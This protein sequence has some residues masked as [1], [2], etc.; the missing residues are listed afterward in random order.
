M[1]G[2]PEPD[3]VAWK[4][5]WGTRGNVGD[6]VELGEGGRA[7]N[8]FDGDPLPLSEAETVEAATREG[9]EERR[10]CNEGEVEIS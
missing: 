7:M 9:R 6:D 3:P 10:F 2:V 4:G 8:E 1:R 5:D